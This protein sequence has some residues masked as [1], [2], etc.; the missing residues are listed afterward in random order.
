M[1]LG[2]LIVLSLDAGPVAAQAKSSWTLEQVLK[3]LDKES[4]SFRSLNAHVERT[5]VTVVVNDR[6]TE[7]GQIWVRGD[8]KMLLETN[9]PEQRVV[10]RDGDKLFIYNPRVK[11]LQEIDL[12]EYQAV[13]DQF[14]LLGF[15]SSGGD[16]KKGYLVTLQGEQTL[17]K[18]KVLLLELTP[19]SEKVRNYFAKIHLW[20][21]TASWLPVQQ[22]FFETGSGDYLEI[23]YTN[24]TRNPKIPD[25][26]FKK[27][28]P[29]GVTK[30]KI[31]PQA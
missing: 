10:L 1:V 5:K 16:L 17:D 20:L 28:W 18:K 12:N 23:R 13:A 30:T 8:N 19:K 9:P 25:S 11:Q 14:L 31:K 24:V 29:R 27:L 4:K 15:G 7:T 26:R 22:K 21:D 3:Q 6:S 2:V